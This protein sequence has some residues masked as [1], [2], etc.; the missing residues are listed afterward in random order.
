MSPYGLS[1]AAKQGLRKAK[2]QKREHTRREHVQQMSYGPYAHTL[3]TS[4][5][6][7]L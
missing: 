4:L 7:E 2:P 1:S 6:Q 5:L 3:S